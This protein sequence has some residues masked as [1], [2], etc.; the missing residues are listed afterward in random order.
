[1]M[2][3]IEKLRLL[4]MT[5]IIS[6]LMACSVINVQKDVALPTTEKWVV[7][8][9][10]NYS[11]T[12]RAGEQAEEILATLLR[13]RGLHGIEMYQSQAESN[14]W[15][16]MNDRKQQENA[17][18][19]ARKDSYIYAVA[20]SVDEWQYKLGV[21]SEPAVGLTLRIIEIASGKVVWS[22]SGARAGWSTESLNST[23]QKLLRELISD[24]TIK[25]A[26]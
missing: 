7:L 15:S 10:Q 14:D 12:P 26:S 6:T 16:E 1:M 11:Q 21:G 17:L 2:T 9:F 3:K 13:I 25:R 23:A 18:S 22:A 24:L 19:K 20:G 5:I 8:P 4:V